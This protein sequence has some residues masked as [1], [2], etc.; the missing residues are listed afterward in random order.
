MSYF[1]LVSMAIAFQLLQNLLQSEIEG[2]GDEKIGFYGR[3]ML[4][5]VDPRCLSIY[6]HIDEMGSQEEKEFTCARAEGYK[7]RRWD[8]FQNNH[9]QGGCY[10]PE[11]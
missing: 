8:G 6:D 10:V 2:I 9:L 3:C 7:G 4:H 5:T 11:E 1:R